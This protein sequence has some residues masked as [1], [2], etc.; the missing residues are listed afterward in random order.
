MFISLVG[1]SCLTW[2][3]QDHLFDRK[4]S[5]QKQAKGKKSNIC[6]YINS[7]IFQ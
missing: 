7:I 3:V 4:L 6:P 2:D 5:A 1:M